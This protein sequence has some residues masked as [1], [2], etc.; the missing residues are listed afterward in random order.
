MEGHFIVCGMGRVGYRVVNL[1]RRLG[2]PVTVINKNT[3][4]EWSEMAEARSVRMILGDARDMRLLE[5]A[6]L[7]SARALLIAT[8]SDLTNIEIALDVKKRRPDLPIVVRIFDQTL[9]RQLEAAFDIRRALAMSVIAAPT[10]AALAMGEDVINSFRMEDTLLVAG[11]LSLSADSPLV[12]LP[13]RE[14]GAQRRLAVLSCER[15]GVETGP[16]PDPDM[17]LCPGDR[18]TLLG[19]KADWDWLTRGIEPGDRAARRRQRWSAFW[20]QTLFQ[21]LHPGLWL[22]F[23]RQVWRNVPQPLKVVFG[24]LN[25]LFLISVFIFH[26]ALHLSF[27]DALYFIVTTVTTVGYG[28]FNVRDAPAALKLYCCVLMLLGSAAVATL[29]SII[30]DFIVTARFLQLL[31]RQRIPQ[32]GHFVVVGL[33]AVG[34][35]LIDKL[36][37]AG[38]RVV[39]IERN[40]G[41]EFVEAVR[42]Q[43]PVV[44]GD[45]RLR[46]T[47]E[48][49][50]VGRAQAVLAVTDDD[51]AN[52][53]IGLETKQMNKQVRTVV[54]LFD[55]DFAQKVQTTL[56]IDAA[57]GAFL[58]AAPT[59]VA[60]ALY[61]DVRSGFVVD[62][63]LYIVLERPVGAEWHRLN[64]AQLRTE[65]AVN[66]IARCA[67]AER[68]YTIA[69]DDRPLDRQ[70]KVL[71]VVW[72]QLLP[73]P[74]S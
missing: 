12:G 47:L 4:E 35:R 66:V 38:A 64:P 9:A 18:V 36:R 29:Y 6:G 10:F 68:H 67:A 55:P 39:A 58:I 24:V 8:D 70:E 71:A 33:G 43:V 21:S 60:S 20:R 37:T 50:G 49:A 63:R 72:R 62:D 52:L 16:I 26:F 3:R 31:G 54:R 59:F 73:Q 40:A 44:I 32:S 14:C 51:A 22:D 30:T 17:P 53:S 23:V 19:D 11:R 2:E 74:S 42:G 57:L 56:G 7:H 69:Y 27:V 65:Q 61:P 25:A 41:N 48:Q 15:E 28:D 45:A 46:A 13:V 1:L 34:Y 5:E